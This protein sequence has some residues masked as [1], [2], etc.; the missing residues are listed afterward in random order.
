MAKNNKP[1]K[2]LISEDEE[3]LRRMYVTKFKTEGFEVFAAVNGEEAFKLALEN[4]PDVILLDIIMP[5]SDG[6]STLKK[7]KAEEKIK[8]IP[9]MM[10]TNLA[11]ESDIEEG[12][13]LGAVDYLVKSNLTP[14]QV[15]EKIRAVLKK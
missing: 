9:V 7:I 6:F 10:L 2:V 5:L 1:I 3:I 4:K 8:K 15:V 13:K 14:S 11:Q 12:K